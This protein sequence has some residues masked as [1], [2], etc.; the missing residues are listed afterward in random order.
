MP[1]ARL[2]ESDGTEQGDID[3]EPSV[4]GIEPNT[5]AIYEAEKLYLANQ[6]QGTVRTQTRSDVSYTGKKVFRQKGLGR[7]RM[8]SYRSPSR[9]GGGRAFG[10]KPRDYRYTIPKKIRRL[11]IRS[12]LSSRAQD[13]SV[14]VIEDL[15]FD[16]PKTKQMAGILDTMAV[17]NKKCLVLVDRS[18]AFV[19]KSCRN[20][21]KV[22]INLA[23]SA[24]IHEL[25]HHEVLIFTRE[26]LKQVEEALKA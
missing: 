12:V 20:I 16:V 19:Y 5:N 4:F 22:S 15:K 2:Y 18:D 10:P 26:G 23:S 8:G 7:A 6:R 11:A 3:L 9:V 25:L 14:V 17:N 24:H 13:G 21:P 1:T